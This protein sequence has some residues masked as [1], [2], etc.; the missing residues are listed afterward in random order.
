MQ[1]MLMVLGVIAA[2]GLTGRQTVQSQGTAVP[3]DEGQIIVAQ[4]EWDGT[5]QISLAVLKAAIGEL[6][7]YRQE[8]YASKEGQTEYL[9]ELINEKLK[10]LAA[11]EKGF[12]TDK[13]LL[14]AVE[15]YEHQ[16]MIT[17]LAE[18]EVDEKISYTEAELKGYYEAHKAEY[19]AEEQV[20]A[21][22][23][24]LTD[25]D[26]AQEALA[27]IQGGKDIIEVAKELSENGELTGPGSSKNAP[28]TTRPF[29]RSVYSSWQKFVDAVFEQEIAEMTE[30]VF[31]IEIGEQTYYMI[32]RKEEHL[33]ERQKSFD[34]VKADI[35]WKVEGEKKPRR[36]TEWLE[37]VSRAG[38]LKT[39]P[40][41]IPEPSPEE[42][43]AAETS[44]V[45]K[46]E[47]EFGEA[48]ATVIV[49]FEWTGKHH[50]T[51]AEMQQEI[52]ELSKYKQTRYKGK[53]GL[54]E[55]MNLMAESR[56]ILYLAKDQRLNED[57][58]I[59]KEARDY[60]HELMVEK[61]TAHEVD[62]KLK[63]TEEDYRAY[64]EAHKGDYVEPE[65][66]RLICI[67]L[68]EEERAEDVFQR[69]KDGEG[70]ADIAKALWDEGQLEGPGADPESPGDTGY[71]TRHVLSE[72]AQPFGDAAFA[73][74]VG[75][76]NEE[77]LTV[78]DDNQ[79]YYIIFRK[80]DHKAE[81]QQAFE[82]EDVRRE[83]ER[84]A[85]DW[86]RDTLMNDWLAQFRERAKV[87]VFVD[88]IPE[89]PKGE[90][91]SDSEPS[92]DDDQSPKPE[93]GANGPE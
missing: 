81:R 72:A 6:S 26:R 8:N 68:T 55:Y 19:V 7:K 64:Y 1:K 12:D 91:E 27:E 17:R 18:I 71:F 11:I 77:I 34:E 58:E 78:G 4:Y 23:I 15:K 44:E 40:D 20:R 43:T 59:V 10:F 51:L 75:Q 14:T 5:H 90:A 76:M 61:I 52:S 69:I 82:E 89:T 47:A 25:R 50:I 56:L 21:S 87:R 73:L 30:A 80:E 62:Q 70:I 38:M 2:I 92:A 33:P 3:V 22:V 45:G 41:R 13:G 46:T 54:E 63:L 39:Y 9:E 32:F 49:E 57:P 79:E 93:S 35:G 16:L 37:E 66:V 84:A 36:F 65:Q 88:R 85:E 24:C 74:D 83:V 48:D 31:E 86:R 67:S 53:V 42:D 28:G 60:F 29:T